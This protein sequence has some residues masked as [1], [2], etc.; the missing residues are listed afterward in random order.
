MDPEPE[1]SMYGEL[2]NFDL[3]QIEQPVLKDRN[4]WLERISMCHWK[5]DELI[6]GSAWKFMRNYV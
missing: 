1:Y 2:A 3:S 5:F 6:D 4:N